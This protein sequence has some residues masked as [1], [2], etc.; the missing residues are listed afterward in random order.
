MCFKS[1]DI[2][3]E[4]LPN[5]R[6]LCIW[7]YFQKFTFVF[8][9]NWLLTLFVTISLMSPIMI[10]WKLKRHLNQ[11][12]LE[13]KRIGL[14]HFSL[15]QCQ[16]ISLFFKPPWYINQKGYV[17]ILLWELIEWDFANTFWIDLNK[18][19]INLQKSGKDEFTKSTHKPSS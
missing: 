9:L 11:A 19:Y 5:I 2:C 3:L 14:K 13:C 17:Y 12:L 10:N 7:A 18:C 15:N 8:V 1:G 6:S 16:I 4:V